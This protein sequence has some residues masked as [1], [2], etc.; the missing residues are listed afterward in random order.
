MR[1]LLLILKFTCAWCRAGDRGRISLLAAASLVLASSQVLGSRTLM[2]PSDEMARMYLNAD[3]VIVGSA[4]SSRTDTLRSWDS[5][6]TDGW[7]YHH[8]AMI[9][10]YW[11][12]VDSVLKGDYRDSAIVIHTTQYGGGIDRSRFDKFDEAGRPRYVGEMVDTYDERDSIS[13]RGEQIILLDKQDSLYTL[14]LAVDPDESIVAFY[15]EVQEKGENYFR[16]N[17]A[18]AR[19]HSARGIGPRPTREASPPPPEPESVLEALG[20]A[21]GSRDVTMLAD[22]LAPDF[23]FYP[24]LDRHGGG[25]QSHAVEHWDRDQEIAIH[26]NMFNPDFVGKDGFRGAD[27]VYATFELLGKEPGGAADGGCWEL[28]F[29][30]VWSLLHARLDPA[31][32]GVRFEGVARL[33]VKPDPEKPG[34]WLIETWREDPGEIRFIYSQ[35]DH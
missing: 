29:R 28:T 25:Q 6:G 7:T 16:S 13:E 19:L 11:V 35:T 15:R 22:L 31:P 32:F 14:T 34:H 27:C 18:E 24:V 12:A 33:V 8:K 17:Q 2:W 23:L 26:K 4:I 20:A 10:V 30:A 9:D 1:R 21:Y 3:L 5:L